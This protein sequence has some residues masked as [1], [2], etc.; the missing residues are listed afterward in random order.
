MTGLLFLLM[1]IASA[2]FMIALGVYSR[3]FEFNPASLPYQLLMFFAAFWSLTYVMDLATYNLPVKIFWQEMRF[4]VLPFFS[5]LELWLVLA[6]LR[7]DSWISG[8]RLW[9]LCILPGICAILALTSTHQTLFRYNYELITTGILPL[10]KWTNGPVF[11]IYVIYTYI[12]LFI[13]LA[14]LIFIRDEAHKTF[15]YQRILLFIALGFPTVTSLLFDAGISPIQGINF[16]PA[17]LWI[18][19]ILYLIALFRFKFLEIIPI[20]R[21]KVI[22]EMS[23][24]MMVLDREDRLIDVNPAAMTLLNKDKRN[25]LGYSLQEIVSDWDDLITFIKSGYHTHSEIIRE[26][27]GRKRTYEAQKDTIFSSDGNKEGM[28]VLLT[29]ISAQKELQNFLIQSEEQWRNIVEGAPFPIVITRNRDNSILLVNQRTVRQFN[30]PKDEFIGKTTEPFYVDPEKRNAIIELIKTQDFVDDIEMEMQSADGRR[31]WVYASIRKIQYLNEDA[32]FISFADFT[33]RKRL[34]DTLKEKNAELEKISHNLF[35]TNKKL[36]LLSSITRHDILNNIQ[37]VML[38][39]DDG[40]PDA[41][42]NE[43]RKRML[44]DDSIKNIRSLIEFTAEYESI[45]Q[46]KPTWQKLQDLCSDRLLASL[47]SGIELI[48]PNNTI[49]IFADPLLH[50]VFYNL[51]ENSIRHGGEIHRITISYEQ[52]DPDLV[53]I[54]EDDGVGIPLDEKEKIFSRGHGKNTGLGLFFIREILDT[55]GMSIHECGIYGT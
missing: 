55:S 14:L 51:F 2:S 13:S 23:M 5:V 52:R 47:S 43:Q 48:L 21:G 1:L 10:L 29:D 44:I 45:G 31:F 49:E 32:L 54:Y 41:D 6:F 35:S 15:N 50:K 34:E 36:H 40:S 4:L 7:R 26:L 18:V 30:I 19:G 28:V 42:P 24:P 12:L 39:T 53:V 22:N 20:A 46:S 25:A 37:V 11:T 27:E 33:Q 3:R 38:V 9:A 8:L 17:I 16:T